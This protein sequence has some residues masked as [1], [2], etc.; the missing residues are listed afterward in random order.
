M[1]LCQSKIA[2]AV[3]KLYSRLKQNLCGGYQVRHL[4]LASQDQQLLCRGD[5]RCS[6][7]PSK[8]SAVE[9]S[10]EGKSCLI[11]DDDAS[12]WALDVQ[13]Q[14]LT[15]AE[16][17]SKDRA[18]LLQDVSVQVYWLFADNDH[19]I[20]LCSRVVEIRCHL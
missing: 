2:A 17:V 16:A 5:L 11:G 18:P 3:V 13:Q 15:R 14:R 4:V 6:R 19:S 7:W 1:A 20:G 8:L 12:G 10:E 9:K